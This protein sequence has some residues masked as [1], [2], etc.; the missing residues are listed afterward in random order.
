[1][2]LRCRALRHRESVCARSTGGASGGSQWMAKR[3]S[4]APACQ[5]ASR[6][7]HGRAARRSTP[8]SRGPAQAMMPEARWRRTARA[9]A[10]AAA[11]RARDFSRWATAVATSRGEQHS[12]HGP[13]S[14]AADRSGSERSASQPRAETAQPGPSGA[15]TGSAQP[16]SRSVSRASSTS[17]MGARERSAASWGVASG[18]RA[19]HERVACSTAGG[20]AATVI[21]RAGPGRGA[22][23]GRGADRMGAHRGVPGR[24]PQDSWLLHPASPRPL[25]QH[26]NR[27]GDDQAPPRTSS[28]G[29]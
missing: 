16:R 12:H 26:A 27:R 24:G 22:P 21:R 15:S 1:M 19:I 18:M 20:R 6:S 11:A 29:L 25:A 23:P 10:A 4:S 2:A 13:P 14:A 17:G 7:P 28:A 3:A 8:S 9:Q 5:R